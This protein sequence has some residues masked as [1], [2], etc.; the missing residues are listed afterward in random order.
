MPPGPTRART[1]RRAGGAPEAA[2][3]PGGGRAADGGKARTPSTDLQRKTTKVAP[4]Q[5]LCP[6]QKQ[7]NNNNNNKPKCQITFTTM[8]T[9]KEPPSAGLPE[10]HGQ[11]EKLGEA[12]GGSR[13]SGAPRGRPPRRAKHRASALRRAAPG[14]RPGNG[15][16]ARQRREGHELQRQARRG[17]RRRPRRPGTAPRARR[18]SAARGRKPRSAH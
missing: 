9:S 16:C 7:I 14:E 18:S 5:K 4:T 2:L 12:T 17:H 15:Q 10:A 13:R 1:W 3:T 8:S 6:P 11:G